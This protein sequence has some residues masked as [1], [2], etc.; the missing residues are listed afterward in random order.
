VFIMIGAK[1]H[2]DWLAPVLSF[3]KN[4]FV[5]TGRDI[6]GAHWVLEREGSIRRSAGFSNPE[7]AR[8]GTGIPQRRLA[9]VTSAEAVV[10]QLRLST[11]EAAAVSLVPGGCTV[12][13]PSIEHVARPSAHR[14]GVA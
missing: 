5:L 11:S 14:A 6:P 7:P 10:S 4:G 9:R 13:R 8:R 12:G 3:D 1:P 2:I